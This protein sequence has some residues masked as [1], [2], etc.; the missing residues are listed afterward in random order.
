MELPVP[1][2]DDLFACLDVDEGGS[3]SEEEFV[4]GCKRL[5]GAAKNRDLLQ[6]QVAVESANATCT[7][8]EED[9]ARRRMK[10]RVFNFENE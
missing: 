9:L 1:D 10:Y 3:L 8:L 2:A 4:A 7:V 6:I 5:R